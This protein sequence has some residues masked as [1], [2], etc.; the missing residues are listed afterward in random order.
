MKSY[1]VCYLIKDD[2]FLML[3]RN[4]KEVDINKGKW[5]GVGGKIEE[6]E[7]P[8]VSITREV[9]EETGYTMEKCILRGMLIFVYNGNTEYI[10]VFTSEDFYGEMIECDEGEL[11]YIPKDEILNLNIWEGDKYFLEELIKGNKEFFVYRMEY[12]NDKLIKVD[13]EQ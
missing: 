4:K 9:K 11:K 6:G 1:T 8:H 3:Y 10:Y 2:K 12:E 13:K 7:S 5:I